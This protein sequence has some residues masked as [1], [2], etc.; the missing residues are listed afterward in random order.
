MTK[1]SNAALAAEVEELREQL[2][3]AKN[4]KARVRHYSNLWPNDKRRTESDPAWQGTIRLVVDDKPVW[5]D[6]SQWDADPS[7]FKSNPPD[8]SVSMSET[9][10]ERAAELE[11]KRD[12]ALREKANIR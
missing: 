3:A 4:A 9:P 7:R 2:E 1:K 6:I 10:A 12:Q 11:A 8:F 5:F